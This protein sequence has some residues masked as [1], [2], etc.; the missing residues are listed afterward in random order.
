LDWWTF[1]NDA[2]LRRRLGFRRADL[3]K[4]DPKRDY[5]D[6]RARADFFDTV[7]LNGLLRE[8]DGMLLSFGRVNVSQDAPGSAA[9][10]WLPDRGRGFLPR[11]ASVVLET[12]LAHVPNHNLAVEG[13]LLVYNDTNRDRIVAWDR[14]A[15][16]E[17]G[18]VKIP[19]DPAF[20]RGLAQIGP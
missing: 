17:R 6:P 15:G 10:V 18:S 5:R 4:I 1:R 13:D 19:G 9:I 11:R 2:R 7:H 8:G 3:P 16:V 14:G 12:G 20:V